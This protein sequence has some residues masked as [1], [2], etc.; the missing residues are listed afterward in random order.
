LAG[1]ALAGTKRSLVLL[2]LI[3][4]VAVIGLAWWPAIFG[5]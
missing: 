5:I 1:Q 4:G 2:P 3:A